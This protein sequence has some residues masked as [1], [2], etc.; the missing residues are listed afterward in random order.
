M[1]KIASVVV[2]ATVGTHAVS[3]I[4]DARR[5]RD[6]ERRAERMA[7]AEVLAQNAAEI[8][9]YK[10]E[11][12]TA[13][14]ALQERETTVFFLNKRAKQDKD[15]LEVVQDAR[16]MATDTGEDAH[17][18]AH[19]TPQRHAQRLCTVALRGDSH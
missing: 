11:T 16:H 15:F 9:R 1:K 19:A 10:D 12:E 14:L 5:T 17:S 7:H 4:Q 2:A 6:N 13:K 18:C 3:S 8:E